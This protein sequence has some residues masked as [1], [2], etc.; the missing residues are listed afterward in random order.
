MKSNTLLRRKASLKERVGI[1]LLQEDI[2]DHLATLW[3]AENLCQK[4]VTQEE[5][6][7]TNIFIPGSL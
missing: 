6:E 2:K 4:N 1:N 7:G 5:R 3:R